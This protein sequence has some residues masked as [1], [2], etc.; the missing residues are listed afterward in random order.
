MSFKDAA[1]GSTAPGNASPVGVVLAGGS[2]SRM[3]R[4]KA[5]L[6]LDGETLAARACRLLA[7]VCPV[8]KPNASPLAQ[9]F[10]KAMVAP[11]FH[12]A[13]ALDSGFGPV[14]KKAKIDAAA[15]KMAPVGDRAA[16]LKTV[17]WD[18]INEKRDDWTKRWNREVER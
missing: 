1:D 2:S 4:D 8:A 18:V 9:E 10:V 16:N 7:A 5:V 6:T 17:D 12:P 13:L 3:G 15:L 14:N 11:E